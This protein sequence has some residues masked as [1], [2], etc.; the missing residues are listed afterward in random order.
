VV[1]FRL[2][3]SADEPLTW[4]LTPSRGDPGRRPAHGRRGV[5]LL[6]RGGGGLCWLVA[7]LIGGFVGAV[8]NAWILLVE[9]HR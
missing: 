4:T 6:T 3:R 1:R 5:S 8:V 7:A 9:I 2:P